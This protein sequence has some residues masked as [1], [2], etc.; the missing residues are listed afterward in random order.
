[1]SR[2]PFLPC[3]RTALATLCT[4]LL[5]AGCAQL[6]G[7]A[8]RAEDRLDPAR[9]AELDRAI[10]DNIAARRLPGAVFHLERGGVVYE[11][12]YGRFTYDEGA[13]AVTPATVFDA[14]SLSKVLS[15]APAVLLLA[16][17]GKLDLEAPLARYLPECA[18]GGKEAIT[19]RQLLTHSS[20][21]PA[22]LPAKPA[23]QGK[24][25]ALGLACSQ[26]LTHAPG[27]F[28]R[29]SDVNYILLGLLVEKVSGMPQERF[30]H[31][32]IFA[33]LGMRDTGYLPLARMAAARIAP[34]QRGAATAPDAALHGDLGPGQLLQ[35]VVH[36]PTVRRMGG[37]GGSAGVFSTVGDVARFGRMLVQGGELDGVRLLSRDSV[38]L[39]STV[40]SPSGLALRGMGMDIDSPYAQRPRGSVFPVGSYGHTGFTGCILWI[41]P[42]SRTFYVFLSNRVYP[43]DSSNVLALYTQLG[44]L[45]AQAAGLEAVAGAAAAVPAQ[46]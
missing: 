37:V 44:T 15:T 45:S 14:A 5:A 26:A 35:G 30:A 29:Y 25:A 21:L 46:P 11:K 9:L 40:Q 38:R 36:D 2:S 10:E 33:P 42:Q 4:A 27:S 19:V 13:T 16:E 43:D 39:L 3:R 23:W 17:E 12:G 1:M 41:D 24:E 7:S 31:E 6:P 34:T 8:M 18:N 22:G 28:F 20:G 32:R